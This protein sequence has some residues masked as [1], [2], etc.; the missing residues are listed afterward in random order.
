MS[1]K[2]S[3][4]LL[5]QANNQSLEILNDVNGTQNINTIFG[6]GTIDLQD[7]VTIIDTSSVSNATIIL[8]TPVSTNNKIITVMLLYQRGGTATIKNGNVTLIE[9]NSSINY[10]Q[11]YYLNG[12][13]QYFLY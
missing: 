6:S 4:I 13:K 10:V 12:W 3:S 1:F 5:E 9:L 7:R 8:P 2:V 11:L